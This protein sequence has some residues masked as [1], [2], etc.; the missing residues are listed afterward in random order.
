[1]QND[2]ARQRKPNQNSESG[3]IEVKNPEPLSP[4]EF[5]E[6]APHP[7][8]WEVHA[9]RFKKGLTKEPIIV[10]HPKNTINLSR[11]MQE[12]T[13]YF[14]VDDPKKRSI[15][16]TKCQTKHGGILEAHLLTQY[17]LEDGVLYLKGIAINKTS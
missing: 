1:M 16:C 11:L 8:F 2:N 9:E 10:E 12:G 15:V 17:K 13:H 7:D 14:V 5:K 4:D 3:F 6:Y